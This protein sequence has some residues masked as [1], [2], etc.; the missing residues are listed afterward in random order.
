MEILNCLTVS[1]A[2]HSLGTC[3]MKPR[4]KGGVVDSKLNVYG[5]QGVKIC[6]MSIVPG[7]VGANT[8][9]TAVTVGEKGALLVAEALEIT[10]A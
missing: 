6:D 3:A 1:T 5:I 10:L 8:Y 9:S 4:A 2:W 7:N